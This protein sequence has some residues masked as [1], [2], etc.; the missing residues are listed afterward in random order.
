MQRLAR[1]L[2]GLHTRTL[3]LSR[4]IGGGKDKKK[5]EG[6]YGGQKINNQNVLMGWEGG[7]RG[8]GVRGGKRVEGLLVLTYDY[9]SFVKKKV[10]FF[11]FFFFFAFCFHL[12]CEIIV[13]EIGFFLTPP[14]N[15][16][17]KVVDQRGVVT[18]V[19]ETSS[20]MI[21][22]LQNIKEITTAR[23]KITI[24]AGKDR[25]SVHIRLKKKKSSNQ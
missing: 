11:F 2:R 22:N 7:V 12:L 10:F 16:T 5:G 23:D 15:F 9:V 21:I 25:I 14:P 17:Q 18:E 1:M 3:T 19:K 6:S 13:I 4:A 20:P 24:S 8:R